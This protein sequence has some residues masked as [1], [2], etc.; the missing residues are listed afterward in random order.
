[1]RIFFRSLLVCTFSG[2]LLLT[3]PLKALE[4]HTLAE[5]KALKE[6]GNTVF[7]MIPKLTHEA[8]F[9]EAAKGCM[10]AAKTLNVHCVYYGDALESVRLQE[11]AIR[12]VIA[13][14]VD[15]IAL[16]SIQNTQLAPRVRAALLAWG[17]P[18]VA[19]DT[20]FDETLASAYIGT[21]NYQLGLQLGE[22]IRAHKPE[23]GVYC[24]LIGRMASQNLAERYFGL[25]NGL[26]KQGQMPELW[27]EGIGCPMEFLGDYQR[28]LKQL[29]RIL[30][31][32]TP[33][34]IVTLG[35]GPQFVPDAYQTLMTP[36]K[37]KITSGTLMIAAI[38]IGPAQVGFIEQGLGSVNVGQTPYQMGRLALENLLALLDGKDVEKV[39]FT[40]IINC[41]KETVPACY[42]EHA[43]KR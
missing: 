28:S 30:T 8:F 41:Q 12:D 6:Q 26:S 13:I 38:D 15:G 5:I 36:H 29:E 23:G 35:G 27:E 4:P 37:D 18:L 43:S 14:G 34:V 40:T 9:D 20:H 42:L 17:K 39:Q 21:D 24:T 10:D 16:S 31:K 7:V 19:F 32:H 33:D 22:A 25:L 3:L 11:Q 2:L 1:M